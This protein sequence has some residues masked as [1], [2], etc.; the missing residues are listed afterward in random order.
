MIELNLKCTVGSHQ[1]II[2]RMCF[3]NKNNHDC[4]IKQSLVFATKSYIENTEMMMSSN[5]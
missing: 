3:C 1:Q 2:P 5:H 4:T